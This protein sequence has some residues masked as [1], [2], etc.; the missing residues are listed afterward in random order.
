MPPSKEGEAFPLPNS[1]LP[2]SSHSGKTFCGQ[3]GRSG[4]A[5]PPPPTDS[6]TLIS[7]VQLVKVSAFPFPALASV[8]ERWPL[9]WIFI[10]TSRF[11]YHLGYTA[12]CWLEE[13]FVFCN[14][15]PVPSQSLHASSLPLSP[16]ILGAR[17]QQEPAALIGKRSPAQ[18][19]SKAGRGVMAPT[20]AK[21]YSAQIRWA[22]QVWWQ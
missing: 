9:V 18:G 7:T 12:L 8:T 6:P 17:K 10:S 20:W 4:L 21:S 22:E 5:A 19:W 15:L 2:C 11:S 13:R 1:A 16:P 3:A 14:S